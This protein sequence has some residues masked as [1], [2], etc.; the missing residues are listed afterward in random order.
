VLVPHLIFT[1]AV[2]LIAFTAFIALT[3]FDL[4]V[5]WLIWLDIRL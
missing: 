1:H 4:A 5:I 3:A 2:G